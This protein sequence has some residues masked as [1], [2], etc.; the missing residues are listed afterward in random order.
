MWLFGKRKTAAELLRENKRLL[1][2]SIREL[3]RERTGLQNQEKKLVMEIKKM[4]KEGQ[5]DAVKVMAK[6]LVRNRHAVNKMFALKSQL[7]AVS[8][9]IATLKSTHAMA[10]AMKGATRAM[11]M[12][13]KRMNL[14]AL[15]KIMREFERQNEKMEMTSEMMGDAVDG[16]FEEG[17]EEEETDELVSQVLDEI[18]ISLDADLVSAPKARAGWFGH[19]LGARRGSQEVPA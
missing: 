3:D 1:D 10:D 6:S 19:T 13:N 7:Q 9:R 18:G 15:A 4:A 17:G 5:M 11:G 12:M 14:P 2:R 16:A 8:L